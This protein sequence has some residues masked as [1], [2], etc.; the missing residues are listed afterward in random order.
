MYYFFVVLAFSRYSNA[1][2]P[3]IEEFD[4]GTSWVFTNGAGIQNYGGAEN[5]ATFN[6]GTTAYPNSSV[7][8]ITSP[9]YDLSACLGTM[10]VSFPLFGIIENTWDYMYFQYRIGAGAWVTVQFFTGFQNATF[11]YATIPTT[12]TQFRFALVTDGSVNTYSSGGSVNVYYYDIASFSIT[13]DIVLPVELTD[14]SVNAKLNYNLVNWTTASEQNSDYF[15]LETSTDAINWYQLA[16]VNSAGYSSN[17]QYYS[18]NDY[19]FKNNSINYYKLT[20]VDFDGEKEVFDII[21]INNTTDS[22]QILKIVNFL[23]Q[24]VNENYK[25]VKIIIYT[26]GTVKKIITAE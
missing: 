7:I 26:D 5:Y 25:G 6:I 1:Q 16:T 17:E 22:K 8:T 14:F 9:I 12:A 19:S 3:I 20:Q 10:I 4:P 23:G 13:C 15:I 18:F 24:E 2:S 21:Q 11:T